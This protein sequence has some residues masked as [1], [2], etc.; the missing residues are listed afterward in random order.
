VALPV[1]MSG[2]TVRRKRVYAHCRI[3]R[4]YAGSAYRCGR[5]KTQ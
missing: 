1:A 4:G 5:E 3:G 2:V